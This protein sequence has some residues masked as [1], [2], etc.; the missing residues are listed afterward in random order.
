MPR[1]K[2]TKKE[3]GFVKDYALTENGTQSALKHY[4]TKDYKTASVIA[5]ENLDKPKI[6]EAI[7]VAKKSL[8]DRIP[9]DLL[10]KAHIEGLSATAVRFTPEGE[11]LDVPDYSVRHKYVD[12][13]YKLKGAYAPEKS[14][15][16]NIDIEP[17][18]R[19]KQLAFKLLVEQKANEEGRKNERQS[20]T[21]AKPSQDG[22]GIPVQGSEEPILSRDL[23]EDRG[24][25]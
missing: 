9:D 17:S 3:R 13:G 20:E 10:E 21:K 25:E 2:L 18:E 19:I 16:V 1:A 6:I 23:K 12:S 22:Q 7:E 24:K 15:I 8:A 14:V 4:D 11:Q 5:S